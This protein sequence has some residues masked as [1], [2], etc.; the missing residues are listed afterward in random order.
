MVGR[1]S[2]LRWV[3]LPT[4]A[5]PSGE[6]WGI[7]RQGSAILR[8]ESLRRSVFNEYKIK[9]A[10]QNVKMFLTGEEFS[11]EENPPQTS[12]WLGFFSEEV[13]R[14]FFRNM[15]LT[16][17]VAVPQQVQ[18]VE[19]QGLRGWV[20]S[21]YGE[22][23]ENVVP[24]FKGAETSESVVPSV[25]WFNDKGVLT[26]K[27]EKGTMN[28]ST[29]QSHLAY[30]RPLLKDDVITYEFF[31]EQGK[32]EAHPAVGNLVFLIQ[33]DEIRLHWIVEESAQHWAGLMIDNSVPLDR[34]EHLVGKLPLNEGAW[35]KL[36][37]EYHGDMI[38]LLLNETP[39]AEVS[40]LLLTR[41]HFGLFHYKDKTDLKVRNIVLRGDWPAS[42]SAEEVLQMMTQYGSR[43]ETAE[44]SSPTAKLSRSLI[45]EEI[46]NDHTGNILEQ[47]RSMDPE[48]AYLFLKKWVVPN[49][50][51]ETFRFYPNIT[52]LSEEKSENFVEASEDLILEAPILELIK[53]AELTGN[54]SVLIAEA[55]ALPMT[56]P[57]QKISRTGFLILAELARDDR[58]RVTKLL[59]Q[60]QTELESITSPELFWNRWTELMVYQSLQQAGGFEPE[61]EGL[62]RVINKIGLPLARTDY[63]TLQDPAVWIQVWKSINPLNDQ[64]AKLIN[65]LKP[66]GKE[67][68]KIVPA[69]NIS[70]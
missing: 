36:Q 67:L 52:R 10:P 29:Q 27:R 9:V 31:Y 68:P 12:P 41:T 50:E 3:E 38:R 1:A 43:T 5:Q 57:N 20:G 24:E 48:T 54:L 44:K 53:Q 69:G 19:E 42:L 25:I 70:F 51:H 47:S 11:S 7:G 14:S 18:L 40:S 45:P 4:G 15:K 34:G 58:E 63:V 2:R 60:F 49:S 64:R 22:G 30:H 33:L 35:N 8:A 13:V 62:T 16:G 17:E 65:P 66:N 61:L 32:T 26:G 46:I 23:V 56:D 37:L 21:T 6:V 39:V 59:T 55:K 28:R